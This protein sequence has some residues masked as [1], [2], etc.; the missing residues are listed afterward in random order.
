MPGSGY[1]TFSHHQRSSNCPQG[2]GQTTLLL[3]SSAS[4]LDHPGAERPQASSLGHWMNAP[5]A[6]WSLREQSSQV[7][8]EN[9]HQPRSAD[10]SMGRAA[11]RDSQEGRS[12][13]KWGNTPKVRQKLSGPISKATLEMFY[14]HPS[15]SKVPSS[16]SGP[17][18]VLALPRAV[19]W[20]PRHTLPCSPLTSLPDRKCNRGW[21]IQ[22][23]NIKPIIWRCRMFD[24]PRGSGASHHCLG[25]VTVQPAILQHWPGPEAAHKH[26]L[27]RLPQNVQSKVNCH[28]PSPNYVSFKHVILSVHCLLLLFITLY[29]KLCTEMLLLDAPTAA[30][31]SLS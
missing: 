27:N 9:G 31:F 6:R 30:G 28:G 26:G 18:T 23:H 11:L 8:M 13:T 15:T 21:L 10:T 22:C 24:T 7:S 29:S 14:D 2:P 3:L 1:S 5:W 25:V 19:I 16:I 20:V 12:Q 4:V 17:S